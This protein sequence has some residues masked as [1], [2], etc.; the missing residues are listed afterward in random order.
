MKEITAKQAGEDIVNF[1]VKYISSPDK[2]LFLEGLKVID[3]NDVSNL[4]ESY[5]NILKTKIKIVKDN[6]KP[7]WF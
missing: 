4:E 2:E 3:W 1:V 5:Y 6:N 7:D